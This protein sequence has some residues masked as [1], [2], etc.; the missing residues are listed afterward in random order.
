MPIHYVSGNRRF[1]ETCRL[2]WSRMNTIY[3][4]IHPLNLFNWTFTY[5]P[6]Y[7]PTDPPTQLAII[8]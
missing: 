4:L 8:P 6:T 1:E 7:L 5:L 3:E 2:F